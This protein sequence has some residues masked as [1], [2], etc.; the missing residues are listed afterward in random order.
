MMK[1][2]LSFCFHID[3]VIG[4]LLFQELMVNHDSPIIEYYPE[5]FQTDLN[6]KTH[7]WEAVVLIP[8]ISEVCLSVI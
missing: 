2:A 5:D 6:G 1:N 3:M 8:F 7:D 4:N